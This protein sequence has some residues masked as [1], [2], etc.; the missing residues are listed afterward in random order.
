[1]DEVVEIHLLE[2]G[3]QAAGVLRGIADQHAVDD[4]ASIMRDDMEFLDAQAI[5][6]STVCLATASQA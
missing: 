3:G 6:N 5:F 4:G 1:M 2:W